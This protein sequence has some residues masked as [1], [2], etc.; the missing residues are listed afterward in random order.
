MELTLTE[1]ECELLVLSYLAKQKEQGR[2]GV[3]LSEVYELMGN[4]LDETDEDYLLVIGDAGLNQLR[5]LQDKRRL[6]IN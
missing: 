5:Y 6:L 1:E 2:E 4:K 3:P